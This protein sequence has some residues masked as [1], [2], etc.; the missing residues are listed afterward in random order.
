MVGAAVGKQPLSGRVE[1]RLILGLDSLRIPA[2][3]RHSVDMPLRFHRSVKILPGVRLNIARTG[4]GVSAG[5][6]GF[7]VGRDA[8]GKAYFS[9][10]IPASGVSYRENLPRKHTAPAPRNFSPGGATWLGIAFVVISALLL[11]ALTVHQ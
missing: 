1:C 8:S 6:R 7:H 3:R 4:I 9:A 11:V 10:G 2:I 5:V